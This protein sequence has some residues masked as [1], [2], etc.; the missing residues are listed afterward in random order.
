MPAIHLFNFQHFNG[1]NLVSTP[2]N[3]NFCWSNISPYICSTMLNVEGDEQLFWSNK[4][5]ETLY[6]RETCWKVLKVAF[7]IGQQA[8]F[9]TWTSNWLVVLCRFFNPC[10]FE[11]ADEG[12]NEG[13]F[14]QGTGYYAEKN[15]GHSIASLANWEPVMLP[16]TAISCVSTQRHLKICTASFLTSSRS[17]I[18]DSGKQSPP[19][20]GWRLLCD[21]WQQVRIEN[22]D[23]RRQTI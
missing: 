16:V 18:H 20:R 15:W 4:S 22:A 8:A 2:F 9:S 6:T 12:L 1:D 23:F 13:L 19:E 10:I 17:K 21:F 11:S 5:P 7:N 3:S 14:G